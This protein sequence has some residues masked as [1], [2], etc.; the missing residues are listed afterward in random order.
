MA[1]IRPGVTFKGEACLAHFQGLLYLP[2]LAGHDTEHLCL[3]TVELVEA[4]PGTT[5]GQAREDAGHGLVVQTLSWVSV[6]NHFTTMHSEILQYLSLHSASSLAV[7][8]NS[9]SAIG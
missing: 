2:N 8:S 1:A 3:N 9:H 7:L 6:S 4:A 5:L